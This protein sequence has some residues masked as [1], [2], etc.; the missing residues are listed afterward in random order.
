L[1]Q[2]F[3]ADLQSCLSPLGRSARFKRSSEF[4]NEPFCRSISMDR[5]L[6]IAG[7]LAV[8]F[9]GLLLW[10]ALPELRTIL[11]CLA[12]ATLIYRVFVATVRLTAKR[13][14]GDQLMELHT[15]VSAVIERLEHLDRK[16]NA[17]FLDA[18]AQRQA[19]RLRNVSRSSLPK[20]LHAVH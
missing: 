20:R 7:W 4:F 17:L 14:V 15:E 12:T 6:E 1:N 5:T 13:I 18:Q 11:A 3:I 10:S 16:A 19:A 8:A 9:I 2:P